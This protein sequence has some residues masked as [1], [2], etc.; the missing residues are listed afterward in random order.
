MGKK[1]RALGEKCQAVSEVYGQILMVVVTIILA[2]SLVYPNIP[3]K[4]T[5]GKSLD[6][7]SNFTQDSTTPR[8]KRHQRRM[9][10]R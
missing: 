8:M 1:S 7:S 2:A 3:G 6:R 9:K 5:Q 10:R 4:C